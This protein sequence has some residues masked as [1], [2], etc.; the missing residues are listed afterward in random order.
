V[1]DLAVWLGR[2]GGGAEARRGGRGGRGCVDLGSRLQ[3]QGRLFDKDAPMVSAG[4]KG[5]AMV[6]VYE[7]VPA[8]GGVHLTALKKF[9]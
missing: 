4:G 8:S 6:S 5:L 1:A 7:C 2:A 3:Y 9:A